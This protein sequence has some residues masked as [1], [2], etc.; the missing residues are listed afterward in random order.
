MNKKD[1]SYRYIVDFNSLQEEASSLMKE[2]A[3]GVDLESDSLFHYREKICLLQISTINKNLLV[4]TLA[5]K[6][7]SPLAPVFSNR[8]IRK[9][10]HGSDYDIRSLY[11]DFGIEVSSLFDTQIAARLLGAGETGLASLL[12]L[13]FDVELEKKYQK[14]DWSKRPL[15]EEMLAY[16]VYDTF[17]LI[18][19]SQKLEKELNEKSRITWFEE[20]CDI[21]TRVR[22]APGNEEPLYMKFKGAKKLAP[23]N[24]AALEAILR[25]RDEAAIER[26]RP[27]FKVLSNDQVL[28]LA[29]K[30]P[31]NRN[32]LVSLSSMQLKNMG[33]NILQKIDEIMRMPEGNLPVY[34]K[35]GTRGIETEFRKE[36]GLIKEWRNR[37]A[38]KLELEPSVLCTNSQIQ[39]LVQL[40][41]GNISA[42][43]EQSI[44]KNWQLEL[45]GDELCGVLKE[46]RHT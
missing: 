2:G 19:L 6:D 23:R 26:D 7:I 35:N 37:K 16:G 20:E 15:S 46:I 43:S 14:R 8:S 27:A 38:E 33:D 17:Y 10:L 41:P 28:K 36:I 21:L 5:I 3:I 32:D 1:I 31:V 4:D 42:L 11:R 18:P 40:D 24:L 13:H 25:L 22:F 29:E 12:K 44:L 9:I 39:L 45:F 34:P 30:M